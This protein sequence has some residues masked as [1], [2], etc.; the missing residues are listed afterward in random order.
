MAG[1]AST[2]NVSPSKE[3]GVVVD[4]Y[5][6]GATLF[7]DLN[8]YGKLDAG[9]PT[10]VTGSDGK[11]SLDGTGGKIVVLPAGT[12]VNGVA[13]GGVDISTNA[14]LQKVL[15]AP[16]GATVV[17]PLTTIVAAKVS[18][19]ATAADIAAA[20]AQVATAL[21]LTGTKLT[22][23]DPI[24]SASSKV[25]A[26][27]A[28]ALAAQKAAAQVANILVAMT[29]AATGAGISAADAGNLAV[30]ALA[31]AI[32]TTGGAVNLTSATTIQSAFTSLTSAVATSAGATAAAKVSSVAA[33]ASTSLAAVNSVISSA[34][35]G[36]EAALSKIAAAELSVMS[37]TNGL[38]K[39]IATQTGGG[40][41]VDANAY[42]G[43][44]LL[45]AIDTNAS[46]VLDVFGTTAT[47]APAKPV[48]A[49]G[50]VISAADLTDNV[51][52]L[53]VSVANPCGARTILLEAF[54]SVDPR[55]TLTVTPLGI[56]NPAAAAAAKVKRA[57][58]V[59]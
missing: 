18:A 7:R 58:L 13:T 55:Y 32:P 48:I 30:T 40:A 41:A 17:N 56:V 1:C 2:S 37:S 26:D 35:G 23:Y 10:A 29:A 9:E 12:L 42:Q 53:T 3:A 21:G 38:A 28:T 24:A 5:I 6:K 8:N 31:S 45:N 47:T 16:A 54:N 36:A 20:E 43:A 22:S 33:V 4:G 59:L 46:L 14:A 11:Y 49:E 27:A 39:A 19:T 50:P 51:V 52:S 25:P 57:V 15:S 34:T 44:N